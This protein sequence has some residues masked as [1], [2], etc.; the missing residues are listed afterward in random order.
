MSIE[1]NLLPTRYSKYLNKSFFYRTHTE[2]N[3]LPFEIREITCPFSFKKKLVEHIW[4]FVLDDIDIDP[5]S[6]DDLSEDD[7]SDNG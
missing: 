7:L 1:C 2:W 5:E 3:A 4:K 6:G